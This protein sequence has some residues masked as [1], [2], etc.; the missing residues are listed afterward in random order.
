MTFT[1]SPAARAFDAVAPQF[2][3]RFGAWLSV[4]AQRRAVREA[5]LT[6]FP[7]C[8]QILE[9]GGG[10]GEDA[11]FLASRGFRVT[12]TDP[13]PA[14][15]SIAR[16]KLAPLGSAA[17]ITAAEEMEQFAETHLS[18]SGT[19]FDGAFS[20]F[21][22]LNCVA[23]LKPVARGLARLLKA[24][25]PA[26]LVVFGT[27]SPGEMITEVLR[28]RPGSALRRLK[29]GE[30]PARLS[31]SEF[32]VIYHRSAD[33]KRAFA[34]W[35]V[36]EK[37]IGIGISVPPSAAEP[38]IS[39]HPRLLAAMEATDKPLRHPLAFFGDHVLYQFRR[40]DVQL[41]SHRNQT[42]E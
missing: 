9:V 25:A 30:V 5:L 8:G 7:R 32:R 2:D 1:V 39:K 35:F 3:A 27:F 21:A 17:A 13:S 33:L 10:T 29:T 40:T 37:R 31:G 28:G 15:V 4:A 11:C 38:W 14:M 24:D 12:L 26:M 16:A 42:M 19:L 18:S 23:D 34:P 20:N 6:A 41:S 22:P 36:L